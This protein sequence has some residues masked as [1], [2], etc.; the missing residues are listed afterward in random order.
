MEFVKFY[1]NIEGDGELAFLVT[2]HLD[3]MH[4]VFPDSHEL[5]R[6][7][8]M[9]RFVL[10]AVKFAQRNEE[11]NRPSVVPPR[12]A[13]GIREV[14]GA[15]QRPRC[16]ASIGNDRTEALATVTVAERGRRR[17]RYSVEVAE[18]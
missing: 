14:Q 2:D 9:S 18:E 11:H 7:P 15:V 13:R 10:D 3:K 4:E 16:Q 17:E 12:P 6:M 5:P 8:S 1:H